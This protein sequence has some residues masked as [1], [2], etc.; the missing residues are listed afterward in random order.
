[1]RPAVLYTSKIMRFAF[2]VVIIALVNCFCSEF[3]WGWSEP[4]FFYNGIWEQSQSESNMKHDFHSNA[5]LYYKQNVSPKQGERCPC[6]P[7]CSTFTLFS[8][9]EYGF[10]TGFFMGMD[11]IFIRENISL[12]NNEKH[13]YKLER[14]AFLKTVL[15]GGIYDCPEA[16]NIFIDKDWRTINSYFYFIRERNACAESAN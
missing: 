6:F 10:L 14:N 12:I 9:D 1:M 13:Y 16:N 5:I 4:V 15:K 11:R 2:T 7:S 8:M 3:D